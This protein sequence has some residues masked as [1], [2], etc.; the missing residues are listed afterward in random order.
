PPDAL[1][2]SYQSVDALSLPFRTDVAFCTND[3]AFAVGACLRRRLSLEVVDDRG[4]RRWYDGVVNEAA[5]VAVRAGKLHFTVQLRPALW[6]LGHRVDSRIF[7]DQSVIDIARTLFTEAGFVD[8]A[9]F[10]V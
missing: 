6:A 2:T 4:E 1:V 7:Q 8:R 9:S 10:E 3:D 5:F